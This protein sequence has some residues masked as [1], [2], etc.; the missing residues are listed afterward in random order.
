MILFLGAV[1]YYKDY[2][3]VKQNPTYSNGVGAPRRWD[4]HITQTQKEF[5][6]QKLRLSSYYIKF[7]KKSRELKH[8][9]KKNH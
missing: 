4:Y 9:C 2:I 8:F 1:N 3:V 7:C 5:E 6:T